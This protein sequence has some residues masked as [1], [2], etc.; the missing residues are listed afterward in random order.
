MIQ[1]G[2]L[3]EYL[4]LTSST[5]LYYTTGNARCYKIIILYVEELMKIK[6]LP[7]LIAEWFGT[8]NY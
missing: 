3:S 5:T 2:L 8:S 1:C 4:L 7:T 6:M